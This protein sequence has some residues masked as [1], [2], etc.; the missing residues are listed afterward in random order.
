MKLSLKIS[1]LQCRNLMPSDSRYAS[2]ATKRQEEELNEHQALDL[3]QPARQVE[4]VKGKHKCKKPNCSR[5]ERWITKAT[6]GTKDHNMSSSGNS[7]ARP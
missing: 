6:S 5:Q 2:R 1:I 3:V 7:L 4:A